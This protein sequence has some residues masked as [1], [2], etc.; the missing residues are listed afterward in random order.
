MSI[1]TW[2]L[3]AAQI[4][5]THTLHYQFQLILS[6]HLMHSLSK[7]D[8]MPGFV[9][10][11]QFHSVRSPHSFDDL[12][13]AI[14]FELDPSIFVRQPRRLINPCHCVSYPTVY[15]DWTNIGKN[16]SASL[17]IFQ[18]LDPLNNLPSPCFHALFIPFTNQKFKGVTE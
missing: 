1:P 3:N 18:H 6:N 9:V 13:F 11:H 5:T 15:R 7:D 2:V 8:K 4:F 14:S 17:N 10:F 12:L 16:D